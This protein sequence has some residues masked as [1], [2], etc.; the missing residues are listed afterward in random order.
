MDFHLVAE[1]AIDGRWYVWDAT[2]SAPRPTLVRIGTGRDAADVALSTVLSGGADLSGLQITAIAS[3][4]L[5]H[6]DHGTLVAL[7]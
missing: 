2:R 6:D 1:T 5:P 4:D 3:N 7:C